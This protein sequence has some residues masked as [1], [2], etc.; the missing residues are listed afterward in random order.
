MS[1]NDDIM[2][3]IV[4][5][6]ASA[7]STDTMYKEAKEGFTQIE[8]AYFKL[9]GLKFEGGI[10]G[11]F[12]QLLPRLMTRMGIPGGMG[13]GALLTGMSANEGGFSEILGNIPILGKLFGFLG[14][15]F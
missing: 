5:E 7:Q 6:T 15:M 14:G 12:K 10:K 9:R 2:A 11:V 1:S 3:A 4:N 8:K 13:I